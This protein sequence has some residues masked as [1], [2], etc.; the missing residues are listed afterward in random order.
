MSSIYR[1][2]HSSDVALGL[3]KLLN[4]KNARDQMKV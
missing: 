4:S 3:Q 2:M 1:S